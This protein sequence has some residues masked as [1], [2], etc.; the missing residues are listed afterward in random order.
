MTINCPFCN[1]ISYNSICY[2]HAVP[3]MFHID[4][5]SLSLI[6]FKY[7]IYS[8]WINFKTKKNIS[9]YMNNELYLNIDYIDITPE[10]V[11]HIVDKILKLKAFF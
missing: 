6:N 1:S 7:N 2:N 5:N 8:I 4:N 3:P 11:V 10:T 9:I